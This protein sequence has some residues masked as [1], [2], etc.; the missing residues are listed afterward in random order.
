MRALIFAAV[1]AT[2]GAASAEPVT[3][4]L[5]PAHTQVAFSIDRFG[6]NHVLG[7]FE[8][9]SGELVL[10][11]A[12][13]ANS[14]VRAVIQ[15]GSIDTGNDTRDGH[16]RGERWLKADQFP[17]MEFHSTSVRLTGERTAEVTGDLTLLGQTH[18]VTLNVTLNQIGDSPSDRR[19]S[20]GFSATGSLSRAAWGSTGAANLIGDA[21]AI[22]I[23]A[24]G[25]VP[26]AAN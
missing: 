11:E 26:A 17:T 22:Q 5:D 15:I 8:D 2:A 19:R 21:V 18:P 24:L 13:P 12:N 25:Q 23:E 14:S 3:Y 20:A 4:A 7:R 1:L 16:L 9:V 10:D 6:F